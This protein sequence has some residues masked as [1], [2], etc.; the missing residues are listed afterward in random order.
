M[1]A[2]TKDALL[3]TLEELQIRAA[4][5]ETVRSMLV[6]VELALSLEKELL[7]E[8]ELRHLQ[9]RAVASELALQEARVMKQAEDENRKT[10]ADD[11]VKEL[12]SLS[13]ELGNLKRWKRENESVI[14]ERDQLAAELLQADEKIA[15]LRSMTT[16]TGSGALKE[17]NSKQAPI[18]VIEPTSD[19]K[20]FPET[21]EDI[22]A[23]TVQEAG[24]IIAHQSV[25]HL[26]TRGADRE[27]SKI[28]EHP[29][30]L[31]TRA[32]DTPRPV[33]SLVLE[34]DGEAPQLP[35]LEEHI[36]LQIFAFLDAI[37]IVHLAQ[38]SIGMYSRVDSLFGIRGEKTDN[39]EIPS[40]TQT[41]APQQ[42][43]Q[44]PAQQP[45]QATIVQLPPIPPAPKPVIVPP[46]KKP[47]VGG[48][49]ISLF[50]TNR[51]AEGKTRGTDPAKQPLSAELANSMA[52][53]LS[54]KEVSAIIGMTEKLN[55]R[56]ME[57][58]LLTQQNIELRGKL[59]GTE[60][61][62]AFLADKVREIEQAL[63]KSKDV[64]TKTTQQIASDQEVIAFLDSRVQELEL[65]ERT[66]IAEKK[67]ISDQLISEQIRNE[68][69]I[70]VLSDMLQYERER[71]AENE[72]DWKA[73]RK[74]LIKEV[75]S[76][77][78]HIMALQAEREG[79][80]EQNE[81]LKRAV[82]SSGAMN[83]LSPLIDDRM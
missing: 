8:E 54:D 74:V 59:D 43:A 60:A 70:T 80:Q 5:E 67:S 77:R 13:Q 37:E 78:G 44:Q 3:S 69:K 55:K 4:V 61:V 12:W 47:T 58:S 42:P 29:S 32:K 9:R 15:M 51:S 21:T 1:A 24:D 66:L 39:E 23:G 64:Q 73:T 11:L 75:K 16:T 62:K 33:V 14:Q 17:H 63:Q 53:K 52:A 41:T 57:V 46:E 31:E 34:E 50:Q 81:R 36:L 38:V 25:P 83:G 45:P 68:K 26:A 18:Q 7:V 20:L 79:L 28:E 27:Q 30:P 49:L 35:T 40:E 72:R 56:N 22:G 48:G 76:C 10:L 2:R 65:A 6:D 82:M 19:P 71:A